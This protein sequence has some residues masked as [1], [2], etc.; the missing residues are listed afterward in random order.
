MLLLGKEDRIMAAKR[1]SRR[2]FF[3]KGAAASAGVTALAAQDLKN[4]RPAFDRSADVVVIGGGVSGLAAA[5]HARDGG[6]SVIVIDSNHDIGGHGMLSGGQ[7]VLGG[8]TA[9]QKK[10]GITDTADQVYIDNTRPDH[11]L[12]RYNDRDIVR[13]FADHNA[14]V[15]D[16]LVANGVSFKDEPPELYGA[17]TVPRLQR[18]IVAGGGTKISINERPGSGLVRALETSARAKGVEFLLMF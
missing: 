2:D 10:H 8:G 18:S 15:F 11:G 1:V 3:R 13:A 5:I 12:A 14:A 7:I 16:F 6:A 4:A 9:N 17:A